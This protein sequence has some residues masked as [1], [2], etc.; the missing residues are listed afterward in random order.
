MTNRKQLINQYNYLCKQTN[1]K[2]LPRKVLFTDRYLIMEIN[3]ILTKQNCIPFSI[4][5]IEDML[6]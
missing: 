1:T 3:N 2:P 6:K 5:E 4:E